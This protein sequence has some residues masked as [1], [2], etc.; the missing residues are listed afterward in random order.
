MISG[1][2]VAWAT[3]PHESAGGDHRP[4]DIAVTRAEGSGPGVLD[5]DHGQTT[6]PAVVHDHGQT[7]V[8]DPR[9]GRTRR[10]P[11]GRASPHRDESDPSVVVVGQG[12]ALGRPDRGRVVPVG[13][14]S[15]VGGETGEGAIGETE[16]P[17]VRGPF[18][19][20]D[21]GDGGAIRVGGE[22]VGPG[23]GEHILQS[24]VPRWVEVGSRLT[25]DPGDD[26]FAHEMW[27]AQD[28]D[29]RPRRYL[30]I[31]Q[32]KAARTAITSGPSASS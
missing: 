9:T 2:N 16:G 13:H 32:R 17:D 19:I 8:V 15:P 29:L 18:Q 10:H 27:L 23:G 12:P 4:G 30:A 31:S 26:V 5:V 21:E 20:E 25:G 7:P 24:P 3:R 11:S 28:C 14:R 1:H 6:A 22:V